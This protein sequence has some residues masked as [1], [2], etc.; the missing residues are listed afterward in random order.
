MKEILLDSDLSDIVD[1][2]F[3]P[4]DISPDIIP[5]H[6]Q[7]CPNIA[8]TETN[9][10]YIAD[11]ANLCAQH[12]EQWQQFTTCM[13]QQAL[14]GDSNNP[15]ATEA[16]FDA[17]LGECA[18]EMSDYSAVDLRTCTY[19]DEADQLHAENKVAITKI[20]SGLGMSSPGLV[21]ASVDGILV[22][23]AS[24]E[25]MNSRAT[26][27]RKLVSAVCAAYTGPKPSSCSSAILA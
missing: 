9:C 24:T 10:N 13:F 20:F 18:K 5:T 8:K 21:W 1:V 27:Q 3:N 12:S 25:S 11:G 14:Q 26:W 23:D 17:Q 19:G 7:V 15:L 16:T 22:S 6:P 4:L 2:K